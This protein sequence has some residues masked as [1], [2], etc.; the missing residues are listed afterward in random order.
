[1]LF[2]SQH[3]CSCVYV[4]KYTNLTDIKLNEVFD[5]SIWDGNF[6]F[7]VYLVHRTWSEVRYL[8]KIIITINTTDL[9]NILTSVYLSYVL[10]THLIINSNDTLSTQRRGRS[11]KLKVSVNKKKRCDFD[12]ASSLICGNKC[13]LDAT[14]DFYCRSYCLLNMFRVP[15]CPS[16]GARE[17]YTGGCCLDT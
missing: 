16:S 12:R 6:E 8:Q 17:Y 2:P 9:N 1:M 7:E 15:L 11:P 14:D 3:S 5:T 13:Q 4:S 10:K